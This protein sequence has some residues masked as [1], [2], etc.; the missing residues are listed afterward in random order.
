MKQEA[1]DGAATKSFPLLVSRI[2]ERPNLMSFA[3]LEAPPWDGL[4]SRQA[5]ADEKILFS[6][7]ADG[8]TPG[9]AGQ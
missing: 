2:F 3:V 7:S 1:K 9:T 5:L 6:S 4:F 8:K